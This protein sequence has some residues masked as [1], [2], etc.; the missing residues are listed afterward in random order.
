M[1]RILVLRG[2]ALGDFIVTLPALA[3]LRRRWPSAR[4]E[5]VGNAAAGA[6]GRAEGLLDAVHPDS[7]A[8][9]APLHGAGPLPRDLRAFL[10]AF[11]LV[12]CAWPDPG[13]LV[14][15]H[16]P[17]AEGQGLVR[18]AAHPGPGAPAAAHFAGALARALGLPPEPPH[19]RLRFVS[20]ECPDHPVDR[21]GKVLGAGPGLPQGAVRNPGAGPG[22]TGPRV[23]IHPGSG[24]PSKNWPAARWAAVA[25]GLTGQARARVLVVTGEAEAEDLLSGA[26]APLRNLPLADL[27]RALAG[28]RL[29]LGHDSGV[30]HLAAAVGAPCVLLF[31]PTDPA[32]WAPPSPGV[33]VLREGTSCE[34]LAVPFVLG[35][36]L[37]ALGA[38]SK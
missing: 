17:V 16:F 14:A 26:G 10:A 6:L 23:A 34:G 18:I 35:V 11:D 29:F 1:R 38:P 7:S 9:W 8:R 24:S 28:C 21:P 4:I 13:G 2:G 27:A 20:A 31:G 32:V 36:A 22:D 19:H 25:Q 5:L 15:A 30:S 12:V 3:A 33:R 37:D